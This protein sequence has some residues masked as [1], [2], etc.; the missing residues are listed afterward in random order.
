MLE[1]QVQKHEDKEEALEW[2]GIAPPRGASAQTNPKLSDIANVINGTENQNSEGFE[3]RGDA[4][5]R[6]S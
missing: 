1:P 4:F 6:S 3:D 5:R 2:L